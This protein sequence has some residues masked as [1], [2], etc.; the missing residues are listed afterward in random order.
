[1]KIFYNKEIMNIVRREGTIGTMAGPGIIVRCSLCGEL[2]HTKQSHR[3]ATKKI[4]KVCK[5]ELDVDMFTWRPDTKCFNKG[6]RLSTCKMCHSKEVESRPKNSRVGETKSCSVCGEIGH[7]KNSHKPL[8][9]TKICNKC[10]EEKDI[11]QYRWR[12]KVNLPHGGY[13]LS[14]CTKCYLEYMKQ[15]YVF[16][17]NSENQVVSRLKKLLCSAKD[18]AKKKNKEFNVSLE[19]LDAIYQSQNGLCFYSGRPLSL[20]IGKEALSIDR[21]DN[22]RGYI[23]DNI[24]LTLWEVNCMKKDMTEDHFVSLCYDIGKRRKE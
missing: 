10:G 19:E 3:L 21:K 14:T 1:M 11:N 2:G 16:H 17:P 6:Y 4:C 22:N 23:T 13:R 7:T 18:R 24:V 5:V 8:P 9:E 20:N 15:S 12:A